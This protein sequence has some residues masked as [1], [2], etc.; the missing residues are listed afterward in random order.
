MKF[1][2]YPLAA[3]IFA[4]AVTFGCSQNENNSVNPEAQKNPEATPETVESAAPAETT[5]TAEAPEKKAADAT[6]DQK[7]EGPELQAFLSSLDVPEVVA[8]IGKEKITKEQLFSDIIKQM[9][10]F[11]KGKSLPPQM[12][13]QIAMGLPKIVDAMVSRKLLLELAA[14]DGIKPSPKLLSEQFDKFINGLQ[15]QQKAMFEAQLKAQGLT[16]EQHKEKI[17]AEKASQE[18]AAID[19]WITEKVTPQLKVTDTDVEKYYKDHKSDFKKPET[20]KVAHILIAPERPPMDKIQNMTPDERKA[21]AENADKQAEKKA[22]EVLN[23]LKKGADFAK[24]AKEKSICPSKNEGGVLPAFDKTGKIEGGQG[25]MD[26]TFTDASF[27]LKPGELSGVVK[28]PFG[29]HIIKSLEHN[30]ASYY[31]LK[32]VKGYLKE[33]LQ[34]E[35][36]S[37]KVQ[38]MLDEAKKKDDVKIFL[39]KAPSVPTDKK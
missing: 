11:M 24:L 2:N 38:A 31:P 15:P 28:T 33:S 19:K 8:Q 6:T 14:K 5:P 36:L 4:A 23:E 12:Q 29:Y 7:E 32:D 34:K 3:V 30:Q 17:S 18:M 9:P 27:K 37:K 35:A 25:A 26:K 20:V 21:F 22:E 16:L 39:T 13:A 10:P 1:R